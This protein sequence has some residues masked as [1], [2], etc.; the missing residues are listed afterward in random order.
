[1]DNLL[2]TVQKPGR[3]LGNEVNLPQKDWPHCSLRVVLA[4][5]DVYEI[6]MS[7]LGLLLLYQILNQQ[8]WIG[9]E[10]VFAPWP[11]ME[12]GLRSKGRPL[13]SLESRT[14]LAAFDIVGFSLQYEL[15]YTNVL[16]MLELGGIP[17]RTAARQSGLPLVIGGGPCA[18]NP[19]P[20][21]P[22]FDAFALGDAE[23]LILEMAETVDEWKKQGGKRLELLKAL[24]ALEGVY[25]PEFFKLTYGRK[26]R[27]AEI[28]PRFPEKPRVS[29]RILSNLDLSQPSE[30]PLVPCAR[31]IHDRLS[32]ELA[33]GCTRGCRFCQAGIIYRPIRERSPQEV[34]R[35]V[36][37]GLSNSGY[38]EL[39]LLALSIGDYTGIEELLQRL[40]QQHADGRVAISLPSLRVGTLN[41]RMIEAVKRVR[42]TGFTLAPEAGSERLRRVINK[43]V[44]EIA[45]LDAVRSVY[46]AGWRLVKLYFMMGLPTERDEDRDELVELALKVW[47]E[48]KH[49]GAGLHVSVSTFVPKPH[50]PFQWEK[51]LPLE[52]VD[53]HLTFF[54]KHLRRKGLQFKW[55]L[56]WQSRLEGVFARGDRRLAEVLLLAQR[57]GCR[58]DGWSD[59]LRPDLWG[60]AFAGAGVDPF[61]YGQ[62]ARDFQETLPWAHLDCGVSEDYL[63]E[64]YQK[65]L[66]EVVTA[67]CRIEGC[68]NCGVCDHTRIKLQ[69]HQGTDTDSMATEQGRRE[70]DGSYRYW[71][72]YTKTDSARFLGHLDMV[73]V[74]QRAMRRARLPLAYSQGYNPSPRISLGDALPVGI[75]SLAEEMEVTLNQPVT[76]SEICRRINAEL[77]PGLETRKAEERHHKVPKEGLRVVTYEAALAGET[78]PPEGIHRFLNQSLQ[79]LRQRSKRGETLIQLESRLLEVESLNPETIRIRLTEGEHGNIRVRDL[80]MHLFGLPE[81]Q[82]LDARIVKTSSEPRE[83]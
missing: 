31:V 80:L 16:T 19:E 53:Q 32:L 50:T 68:T 81:E 25:V 49:N 26:G 29:K 63:W 46:S 4:F 48:A 13:V 58:F 39:S 52:E 11:D 28:T 82:I 15:G 8:D 78:W 66:A 24:A 14:P 2:C 22:F 73:T 61:F 70:A 17:T 18:F 64:E 79:P 59:Q 41:E 69:L 38:D 1:M 36:D 35:L 51:Q 54:K 72:V 45:L 27:I 7:H 71:L 30:S 44:N 57:L 3:Y 74:F 77:P 47:R 34:L 65:A 55:H 75:E 33:R 43:R 76:G 60:Q 21:A 5:P 10:R 6:G 56:P 20:V 12:A 40:V 67:D 62:R 83:G 23:E 42:K 9:A 37:Q